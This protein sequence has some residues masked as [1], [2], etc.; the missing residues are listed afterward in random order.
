MRFSIGAPFIGVVIMV[1]SAFPAEAYPTD[2]LKPVPCNFGKGGQLSQQEFEAY[3][4]HTEVDDYKYFDK[5]CNGKIDRSERTE[6]DAYL[7]RV[8][9]DGARA[10]YERY[11]ANK[12]PIVI[13]PDKPDP[14]KRAIVAGGPSPLFVTAL[15]TLQSFR[16]PS[17]YRQ[18]SGATF[19][20]ARDDKN[21]NTTWS[22]KGIVA[23]P[24]AWTPEEYIGR[25]PP[26]VP[27]V[28]GLA[29]TPA[30]TFQ[31]VANSDSTIAKRSDVNVLTY[32]G[33]GEVAIGN[34][35]DDTMT[36]YFR[37]RGA[38]VSNFDSE[39]R[40]W[41]VVA[42]Y[43][44]VTRFPYLPDLSGPNQVPN[45]PLTYQVDALIRMHYAEKI[46]DL[47]DPIFNRGNQALRIGPVVSLAVLPQA[48][49]NLVP[50][51]LKRANFNFTY[52][53]LDNIRTSQTYSHLLASLG[54]AI[55]DTGHYAIKVSYE[56]GRIEETAQ[57][58]AITKIG[59]TARY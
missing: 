45:L 54:Y 8:I 19:S 39:M 10:E 56:R 22:A 27:Y 18:A 38:A 41:N 9:R 15:K 13:P 46:G 30:I 40:S 3:R 58:V 20:Y 52:S 12:E 17:D 26:H 50:D 57:D 14:R 47:S 33:G 16:P 44:P 34:F 31:R 49:S 21:L 42:E 36:H 53:W 4:M 1:C 24:F 28:A 35:I 11:L 37:I 32:A 6:I 5:N 29:F 55:D 23:Y 51:W 59:L 25:R 43:Q 2:S 7:K 48:K